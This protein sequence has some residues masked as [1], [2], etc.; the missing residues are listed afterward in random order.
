LWEIIFLPGKSL[1]KGGLDL[2]HHRGR[3][4]LIGW[5]TLLVFVVLISFPAVR[6]HSAEIDEI[7]AAIQATG[8]K[9]TAREYPA[10]E[11]RALGALE[12]HN[13]GAVA[14]ESFHTALTTLPASFDWRN[15]NGGNYVT[16][17]RNQGNCGSCWVFSTTAALEAKTL[18]TYNWPGTNLDLSEQIVLSCSGGGNCANG[19]YASDAADY[20]VNYGTS[21]E[22]CYPYTQADGTCSSRCANWQS[23]AYKIA[24]WSYVFAG[25][26][27]STNTLKNAIYTSG[28]VVAWFRVYYDFQH[29][30]G[31]GV[32]S[33]TSG[34]WVG[35]HFVLVVGWDDSQNAFIVKNSWGSSW[36]ES[37][38]FRISYSELAGTTQFAS[39][40]YAYG[41]AIAPEISENIIYVA[42][43]GQCG[44]KIPCL[45]SIQGAIDS[46]QT[47]AII[48]ISQETYNEDVVLDEAK[49]L[50]VQGGWDS[51]FTNCLSRTTINGSLT[52]SAGT[53]K[54]GGTSLK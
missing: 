30:Y 14:D 12:E 28:P 34:S 4:N 37:G 47:P 6:S 40:T 49:V 17:V 39:W 16:P 38:Y 53:L 7:N 35:N 19:G 43:N 33:Y 45:N 27:A 26:T 11:I 13:V 41:N 42:Q 18:I 5:G 24:S 54:I 31:S 52:I 21:L 25:G 20:L 2:L 8:A 51:T 44:V 3:K 23:S 9:W 10:S 48:N 50:T 22:S 46:A 32:Y 36:G 1:T 15:Y 29:F